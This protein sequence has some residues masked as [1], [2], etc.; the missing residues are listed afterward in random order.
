MTCEDDLSVMKLPTC[1]VS[2]TVISSKA[3]R[4]P[5]QQSWQ[6]ADHARSR[7]D[8]GSGCSCCLLWARQ[9]P[10]SRKHTEGLPLLMCPCPVSCKHTAAVRSDR[11]DR[12]R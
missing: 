5:V 1:A 7:F 11:S 10:L 3:H 9:A 12:Q 8:P 4:A 2:S 6:Q